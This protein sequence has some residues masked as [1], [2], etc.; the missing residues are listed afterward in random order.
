MSVKPITALV[1]GTVRDIVDFT[2]TLEDLVSLRKDRVIG[3]IVVSTWIGDVD[4]YTGLRQ[5]L[6]RNSITL[7]E[8]APVPRTLQPAGLWN[9]WQQAKALFYGPKACDPDGLVIKTRTDKARHV[10]KVFIP[11]LAS[12]CPPVRPLGNVPMLFSNR[13]MVHHTRTATPLHVHDMV[14]FGQHSDLFQLARFDGRTEAFCY[15]GSIGVE[16]RWLLYPFYDI[17]I[18]Q[19][20]FN[21]IHGGLLASALFQWAQSRRPEMLPKFACRIL[22]AYYSILYTHFYLVN[23]R[24]HAENFSFVDL[25]MLKS[26]KAIYPMRAS[27]GVLAQF[28]S[29][30]VVDRIVT[31]SWADDDYHGAQFR[32]AL[33]E[34]VEAMTDSRIDWLS[35][36][37]WRALKAF[38]RRY[39]AKR[40][41]L[42]RSSVKT[43]SNSNPLEV[44]VPGQQLSLDS[45]I[46]MLFDRAETPH[47]DRAL[48]R[49]SIRLQIENEA[50]TLASIYRSIGNSYLHGNLVN[51]DVERGLSWLKE[52]AKLRDVDAQLAFAK[53]AYADSTLTAHLAKDRELAL[54][55]LEDAARRRDDARSFRDSLNLQGTPAQPL[56]DEPVAGSPVT[57]S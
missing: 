47:D 35:P 7:L 24:P 20:F 42:R 39:S 26:R 11:H 27:G 28:N 37:D 9:A 57:L 54:A 8:T 50:A 3:D 13:V 51:V 52:A 25:F 48:L 41:F 32:L 45:A 46:E 16:T 6:A 38:E 29:Q 4:Q 43:N 36:A 21:N 56:H 10:F 14:I 34:V 53:L 55:W 17:P 2:L 12:G 30:A 44:M 18:F 15:P 33:G 31:G 40:P 49:E 19:E 22:A 23:A 5:L 1:T